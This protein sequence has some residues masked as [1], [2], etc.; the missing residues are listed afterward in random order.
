MILPAEAHPLLFALCPAF[1]YPT[2]HPFA[3]LLAAAVLTPG[4]RTLGPLAEGHPTT[5]RRVLSCAPRSG[6]RL[7]LALTRFLPHHLLPAGPV[8]L[9][10]DDTVAGH[11]GKSAH[12]KARHRGPVRSTRPYTAW[13]Y[14]RKGVCWP[15]WSACPSRPGPGRCRCWS[16]CAA[17]RRTTASGFHTA[18]CAA[19]DDLSSEL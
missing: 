9:A 8:V 2:F 16:T 19:C 11:T 7:G 10:G 1:T 12:G 3:T 5:S 18:V 15:C 14:G 17:A 4:R 13:R 6:P